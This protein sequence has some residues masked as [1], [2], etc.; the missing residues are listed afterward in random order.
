VRI[1]WVPII[2]QSYKVGYSSTLLSTYT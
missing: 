1:V 2:M